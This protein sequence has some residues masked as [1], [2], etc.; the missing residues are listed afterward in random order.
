MSQETIELIK[1]NQKWAASKIDIGGLIANMQ[2]D[3]D[4]ARQGQANIK[5]HYKFKLADKKEEIEQLKQE[6]AD[7]TEDVE[8]NW[9]PAADS[10]SFDEVDDY[11]FRRIKDICRE[12]N[13]PFPEFDSVKIA[14]DVGDEIRSHR[15]KKCR[16]VCDIKKGFKW[17]RDDN[18]YECQPCF[19]ERMKNYKEWCSMDFGT[20]EQPLCGICGDDVPDCWVVNKDGDLCEDVICDKCDKV[21]RYDENEDAYIHR[22]SN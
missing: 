21:W 9:R 4:M 1:A 17:C 8:M 15:C 16:V 22:V 10:I 6:L 7:L 13:L 20:A 3:L 19:D 11:I 2:H 14:K 18:T 12:E 5:M